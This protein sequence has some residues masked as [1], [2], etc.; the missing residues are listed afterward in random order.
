MADTNAFPNNVNQALAM[1]Y[2]ENQDLSGISPEILADMYIDIKKRIYNQI[3][4]K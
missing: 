2:L 4:H 3:E 1:L